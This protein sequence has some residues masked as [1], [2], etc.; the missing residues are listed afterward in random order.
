MAPA[1]D[2][3]IVFFDVF[4]RP[5]RE[6]DAIWRALDPV[7]R[8]IGA[9]ETLPPCRQVEEHCRHED[10]GAN[11]RANQTDDLAEEQTGAS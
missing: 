7:E 11:S 2:C 4:G 3:E 1:D 5:T 9:T 10:E 8:T 6:P